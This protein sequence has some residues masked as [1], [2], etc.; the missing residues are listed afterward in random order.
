MRAQPNPPFIAEDPKAS[1]SKELPHCSSPTRKLPDPGPPPLPQQPPLV[2]R[3]SLSASSSQ[4]Q[5]QLALAC[6]LLL[7]LLL[8][9]PSFVIGDGGA[10]GK[11][12]GGSELSSLRNPAPSVIG[13]LKS[14]LAQPQNLAGAKERARE[15]LWQVPNSCLLAGSQVL[16]QQSCIREVASFPPLPSPPRPSRE[17][18]DLLGKD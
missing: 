17:A 11:S 5:G 13:I 14:R 6:S 16:S 12:E 7:L 15:K 10:C 8:L 2:A 1:A 4:E 18:Q 9:L 3:Y